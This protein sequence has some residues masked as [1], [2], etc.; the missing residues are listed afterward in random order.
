VR[1]ALS[2][3]GPV[4]NRALFLYVSFAEPLKISASGHFCKR[5][6]DRVVFC[7]KSPVFVC[8]LCGKCSTNIC[9]SGHYVHM[10]VY[11]YVYVYMYVYVCIRVC[12]CIYVC[13]R[14]Y[15]CTCTYISATTWDTNLVFIAFLFFS[16]FAIESELI[17]KVSASTGLALVKTA[18]YM[19]I[20][21]NIYI[22]INMYICLRSY[23]CIHTKRYLH[24]TDMSLSSPS[25]AP[26]P[27]SQT[28]AGTGP[29]LFL[30]RKSRSFSVL[31]VE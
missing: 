13:I 21:V 2:Q 19:Y 22:F 7:K 14:M 1:R 23:I 24:I 4:A 9:A 10:C 5:A 6:N 26:L 30:E 16:V 11:V 27:H 8:L 12:I 31:A 15:N 17:I 28:L 25:N 3:E 18:G 20:H 29:G